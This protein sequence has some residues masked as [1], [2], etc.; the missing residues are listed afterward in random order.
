MMFVLSSL[1]TLIL[2]KRN[3]KSAEAALEKIAF[4]FCEIMNVTGNL[5]FDDTNRLNAYP[6]LVV[7]SARPNQ[8]ST[9]DAFV[10]I[11]EKLTAPTVFITSDRELM[12]RLKAAGKE[13][14]IICKPKAWFQ[15]VAN[16][17]TGED[18]KEMDSWYTTWIPDTNS[19]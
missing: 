12:R 3:V 17:L 2:K 15:F 18:V 9:D 6:K 10:L 1:R 16:T 4:K 13:N 14:T 5:M 7:T 11:A 19:N 8:P